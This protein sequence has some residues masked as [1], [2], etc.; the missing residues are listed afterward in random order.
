MLIAGFMSHL[1]D[2]VRSQR[3]RR[4]RRRRRT[5]ALALQVMILYD[6]NDLKNLWLLVVDAFLP[7]PEKITLHQK[8]QV[9][10]V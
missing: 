6:S 3:R 5:R 8:S 2:S 9:Y 10:L 1:A 4:K 7:N